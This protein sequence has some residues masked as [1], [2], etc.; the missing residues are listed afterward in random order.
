MKKI[1]ASIIIFFLLLLSFHSRVNAQT[2]SPSPRLGQQFRQDVKDVRQVVK[3]DAAA[4]KNG[5]A[6]GAAHQKLCEAHIGLAK[7]REL[8][9]GT[10]GF[11]M[12]SRLDTIVTMVENFYTN[13]LVPQGKTLS[14][15]GSL[16]SDVNTKKAAMLPLVDKVKSDSSALTCTNDKANGQFQTF[17]TDAQVLISAF[18]AYRQSVIT[19]VKAVRGV[20]GTSSVSATPSGSTTPEVTP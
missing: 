4:L 13:K 9:L 18:K 11:L 7:T 12:K 20:A 6:T 2:A 16:V 19:L 1:T 5:V 14:N 15:Y 8:A 17:R 10:R 3:Q